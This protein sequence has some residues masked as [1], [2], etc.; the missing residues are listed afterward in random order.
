MNV[1]STGDH[2]KLVFVF[3]LYYYLFYID[4]FMLYVYIAM[5]LSIVMYT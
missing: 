2:R 3:M 5:S 4:F 1:I